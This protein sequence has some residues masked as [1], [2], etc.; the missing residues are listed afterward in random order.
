MKLDFCVLCGT[1]ENLHHHHVIP[2]VKGGTDDEDNF[3]TLCEKH[4]EMIHNIQQCDDFFELA[5][6]GRE[7]AKLRGVRFGAK[8]KHEHLYN[9]I[10]KLY[11]DGNGYGT[12]AKKLDISRGTVQSIIKRLGIE[13]GPQPLKNPLENKFRKLKNGQ[14]KLFEMRDLK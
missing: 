11:M 6:L 5:R 3:I 10:I 14:Y 4:H 7:R 8:P 1:T 2:K 9:E 13:R 12:I